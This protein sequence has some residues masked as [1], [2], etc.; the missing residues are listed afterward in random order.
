M[1]ERELN[2]VGR[3]DLLPLDEPMPQNGRGVNLPSF[4]VQAH[5]LLIL[6]ASCNLRVLRHKANMPVCCTVCLV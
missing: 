6:R 4:D 5:E 1:W 2:N 3:A